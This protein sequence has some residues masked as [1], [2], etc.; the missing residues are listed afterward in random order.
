[1]DQIVNQFRDARRVLLLT[2]QAPDADGLG[3][4]L[5]L[6]SA[7]TSVGIPS[8][9]LV[10][11]PIPPMIRTA[12]TD[13]VTVD[14]FPEPT[15]DLVVVLDTGD[16]ARLGDLYDATRFANTPIVNID[17]HQ[18]NTGF[19]TMN[20]VDPAAAATCEIVYDLI[21][22]LG[23]P[24]DAPMATW[25]LA[26]LMFDTQCF[27]TPSTSARTLRIAADLVDRG[28]PLAE[29]ADTLFH[30]RSAAWLRLVEH[31][32]AQAQLTGAVLWAEVTT[33]ALEQA[34]ATP[35]DLDGIINIL[36]A[37]KGPGAVALFQPSDQGG[38]RVSVRSRDP[39]NVGAVCALFG[40]GGHARA[41][42]CTL[43][44]P[45]PAQR[46]LFLAVLNHHIEA[47]IAV[48]VG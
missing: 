28:A 11:S 48:A 42:G 38:H 34:S 4:C 22:A 14:Q 44:G 37:V 26:G 1:M 35:D 9:V 6:A 3:A 25:L 43:T 32:T 20:L 16:L 5:A 31:V 10:R 17:H 47:A 46:D 36:F 27:R 30:T 21:R 8:T 2:H 39:V 12:P 41:A 24:I 33:A 7:L 15:P 45:W 18:S 13:L 29:I 23:V 40:G 19:G